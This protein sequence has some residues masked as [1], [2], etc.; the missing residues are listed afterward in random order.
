[1]ENSWEFMAVRPYHERMLRSETPVFGRIPQ[2]T[3]H[4][5]VRKRGS[6]TW[7]WCTFA[8]RDGVAQQE[9][10]VTDLSV[11][12]IRKRWGAGTYRV[13]F[14]SVAS[15]T[16]QVFGNGKIFELVGS[17]SSGTPRPAGRPLAEEVP[18]PRANV[19]RAF[20]PTS[21]HAEM[22]RALLAASD[23]R[24]GAKELFE[25]LAVPTGIGLAALF[26]FQERATE[27]LENI[28]RRLASIEQS[29]ATRARGAAPVQRGI[30]PV[31]PWSRVLDKL[32][33]IEDRLSQAEAPRR[34][35]PGKR[36]SSPSPR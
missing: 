35:S 27:Q 12:L 25:A 36:S 14:V 33:S 22:V 5:S 6:L 31:D 3:T 7:E 17:R 13:M 1:M 32:E 10:L 34:S 26:S 4:W 15:G 24:E 8:D 9:F 16:R 19:E 30:T 20:V 21:E 29:L 23:G 2:G 11:T 28:E 18:A